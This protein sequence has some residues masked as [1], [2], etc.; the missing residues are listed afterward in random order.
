MSVWFDMFRNGYIAGVTNPV[1]EEQHAW[2]DLCINL[3]TNKMMVSNV[4]L[5]SV[6]TLKSN[7]ETQ[8]VVSPED[9]ALIQEVFDGI[10][11]HIDENYIRQV[12]YRYVERFVEMT[13]HCVP[14][15]L[16]NLSP[17]W[18]SR[19]EGWYSTNTY[20]NLEKVCETLTT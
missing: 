5:K 16:Q 7:N 9:D 3:T 18:I 14:T 1:F 10:K 12:I 8:T 13:L 11:K 4:L 2:W 19:A 17:C 20:K 15:T 6:E